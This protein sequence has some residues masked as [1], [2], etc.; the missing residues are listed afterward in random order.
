[1]PNSRTRRQLCASE[2]PLAP[3]LPRN[4]SGQKS[5]MAATAT[6]FVLAAYEPT[7]PSEAHALRVFYDAT[8]G[9]SWG[10]EAAKNWLDGDPCGAAPYY[11]GQ[12]CNGWQG[13]LCWGP[14]GHVRNLD[15][16]NVLLSGTLPSQLGLLS[17][18]ATLD[19]SRRPATGRAGLSGTVPSQHGRIAFR[20]TEA[21]LSVL[22]L[23][24][25][26]RLSGTLPAV[27]SL[28]P[29]GL[30]RCHL[31]ATLAAPAVG[32][33]APCAAN[34]RQ[35]AHRA[36]RLQL[37]TTIGGPPRA[38]PARR[39]T[40]DHPQ[41]ATAAQRLCEA[42]AHLGHA[43]ERP[44]GSLAEA[45]LAAGYTSIADVVAASP[46]ALARAV[47]AGGQ[48]ADGLG[49]VREAHAAAV[50][51]CIKAGGRMMSMSS[52]L[53]RGFLYVISQACASVRRFFARRPPW[54]A[55]YNFVSSN[56]L[57]VM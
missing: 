51:L 24:G 25:Q 54:A 41:G 36:E 53:Q 16:H 5:K 28:L 22:T 30:G 43:H 55:T 32:L 3:A 44:E 14:G 45:L 39:C 12:N 19:L 35:S 31:P 49:P 42:I 47:R 46:D 33:P 29:D 13:V 57:F 56:M 8:N 20:R 38:A 18:L 11:C 10:R 50:H 52:T 27:L 7:Q 15:R 37:A 48:A 17:E 34:T 23:R 21:D 6:L 2:T 1:M 26:T 4:K 9:A 40:L